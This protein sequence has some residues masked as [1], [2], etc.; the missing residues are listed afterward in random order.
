MPV[1]N[2]EIIYRPDFFENILRHMVDILIVVNPDATVRFINQTAI[3]ALQYSI[4]DIDG[5][6]VG[7]LF[8]DG[9]L[10]LFTLIKNL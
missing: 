2:K 6:P 7:K 4:E 5:M 3:D 1:T 8:D 10:H 9:E